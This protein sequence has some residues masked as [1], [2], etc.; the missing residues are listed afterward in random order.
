LRGLFRVIRARRIAK[1]ED[2][3][4]EF[5][6]LGLKVEVIGAAHLKI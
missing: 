3:S 1:A 5:R 2:A 6:V 4:P